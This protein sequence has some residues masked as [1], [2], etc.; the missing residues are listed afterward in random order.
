MN[1]QLRRRKESAGTCLLGCRRHRFHAGIG[2]IVSLSQL[3]TVWQ[4]GL[5][6]TPPESA[7][8]HRP[9]PSRS[10]RCSAANPNVASG[11]VL[12]LTGSGLNMPS[13]PPSASCAP[14]FTDTAHRYSH[15]RRR[16]FEFADLPISMTIVSHCS[17]NGSKVAAARLHHPVFWVGVFISFICVPRLPP[18]RRCDGRPWSS[19]SSPCSP[20]SHCGCGVTNLPTFRHFPREMT[21]INAAATCIRHRHRRSPSPDGCCSQA[22]KTT[23][24]A[25][26][27][28]AHHHLLLRLEPAGNTRGRFQTTMLCRPALCPVRHGTGISELHHPSY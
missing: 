10:A 27:F 15:R 12:V 16:P 22:P 9:S 24:A 14:D 2:I 6:S 3:I 19:P 13:A 21:P 7:C 28:T 8:R 4:N 23:D 25:R 20:S 5:G 1:I 18:R 11:R 17:A 26:F